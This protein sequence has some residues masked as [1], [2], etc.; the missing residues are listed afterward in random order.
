MI[1]RAPLT[2][3]PFSGFTP[4]YQIV[5]ADPP[6]KFAS[7][8]K[9]KPGRNAMGH[10]DCMPL[11]E[12][13]ALPVR[14]L[15]AK[16]ALL[17]MWVTVPFLELSLEVVKAWGF[18][19][20][21]ELMWPKD[22]VGTGFWVRNRHEPVLV[23]KRGKFPCPKPAPFADSIIP[24]AQREHSRKP[25]TVHEQ[26]EAVPDW[27]SLRKLE[28]FARRTRP[29]WDVWGNETTKFDKRPPVRID[30]DLAD[31]IGLPAQRVPEDLGDLI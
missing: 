7:N 26:V 10:Y 12:I 13:K 29:G 9:E 5:I 21:S 14:D 24:G 15:V 28:M 11:D 30:D 20:V 23:C 4:G 8:S 22:R 19:Y 27:A 3:G 2:T 17:L 16:D 1:E 6:W 31:L 25:E 18:K